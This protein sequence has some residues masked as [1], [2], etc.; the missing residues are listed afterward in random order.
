MQMLLITFHANAESQSKSLPSLTIG[1]TQQI[2]TLDPAELS[3]AQEVEIFNNAG[4][5]L[6]TYNPW[7]SEL[8]PGLAAAMPEI[9][10]DGL[11]YKFTLRSS[12]QF[13]DGTPLDASAVKWSI[14][15]AGALGGGMSYLVTDYVQQ[16]NV[17]DSLTLQFVLK[18]AFAFF[19]QMVANLPYFP[20]SPNCFPTYQFDPNSTCGGIGPYT[21]ENWEHGVSIEL[22]ANPGY[23]GPPPSIADI[24]VRQ[25]N[26]AAEMRQAL[27]AGEIDVAWKSLDQLDYQ[28]LKT[29]PDLNV[30]EEPGSYIRY[31][32][33]NTKKPP[34]DNANLRVALAVAM[35]REAAAH[36]V[37]SDTR[38]ALYSMVPAGIW[39]HRDSFLDM[40]GQRNLELAR[41]LLWQEGYSE[42]NKLAMELW[43]PLDHYGSLEPQLAARLASN[44]EETGMVSVT[45]KYA[46][47]ST[48]IGN[49]GPGVMPVFLLGWW[50]DYPDPDNLTWPFGYS[51]SS[52]GMGINYNNPVMDGLLEAGRVTTPIWGHT[53]EAIYEVIQELW[54]QDAP[55]IPLVQ[56]LSLVVT[57][58]NVHGINVSPSGHLSYSSIYWYK[59]HLPILVKN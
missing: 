51:S 12:L 34:F 15:R 39:S 25:F 11:V 37:Y 31:L 27:E 54:A 53:R 28:E 6:L 3:G 44:I 26:T 38:T 42:T 10:P 2:M 20:V 9:S 43:Y 35:D 17:V 1:T 16:I 4:S 23:Y 55:T 24:L 8:V 46:D 14:D 58:D 18:Q 57:Q 29:N 59:T 33:I 40:Y 41:S 56:E 50:P 19:P 45:L 49:L 36:A 30:I 48:Y 5:G 32:C 21:I 7:T 52:S 13:T 22:I 47:W